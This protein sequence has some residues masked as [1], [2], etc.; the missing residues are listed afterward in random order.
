MRDRKKKCIIVLGTHRSGTSALTRVLQKCGVYLG[1]TRPKESSA[2]KENFENLKLYNFNV[3]MLA[4]Y[5]F[6]WS[7]LVHHIDFSSEDVA[8][9]TELI[10]DE[11]VGK[12]V[13]AIKEPT[14]IH[15]FPLY[16]KVLNDLDIDINFLLL[17]R[18]PMEVA[19]ALNLK[20]GFSKDKGIFLWTYN[21]LLAE[22][23]SREYT[24]CLVRFDEL[25]DY[26]SAVVFKIGKMLDIDVEV[27]DKLDGFIES[28]FKYSNILD[29]LN[30]YAE[31]GLPTIVSQ[32]KHFDDKSQTRLYDKFLE[33]IVDKIHFVD[34]L[35]INHSDFW[36]NSAK[37]TAKQLNEFRIEWQIKDQGLQTKE[38][39][40]G[41][42]STELDVKAK[43]IYEK[44]SVL[45]AKE[46]KLH[47]LNTEL[48]SKEQLLSS[49]TQELQEKKTILQEK[50]HVLQI[51][52]GVLQV[53]D[54]ELQS[55]DHELQSKDQLIQAREHE[56]EAKDQGIQAELHELQARFL[57]L[58]TDRDRLLDKLEG[59]RGWLGR[60]FAKD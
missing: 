34:K 39:V 17:F 54:E 32:I 49:L 9:L 35:D 20:D 59:K 21:F 38:R 27:D 2:K 37:T 6:T 29:E 12:G 41:E 55:K 57:E 58:Q 13:F 4:K 19:S 53:K 56:F 51:K 28:R 8:K 33:S 18:S 30:D 42:L 46:D 36:S 24:R 14:M 31:W 15:L 16:A 7:D 60:M 23:Y 40:I 22:K 26:T 44:E 47:S 1:T 43:E 3:E 45:Q 5:N 10:Q 25:V 48:N 50:E 52:D 11:F